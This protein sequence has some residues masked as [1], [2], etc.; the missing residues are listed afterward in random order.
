MPGSPWAAWRCP[1]REVLAPPPP[2]A[3]LRWDPHS[4]A[5]RKD[6]G[7]RGVVPARDPGMT[8]WYRGC[9]GNAAAICGVP[10]HCDRIRTHAAKSRIDNPLRAH[11]PSG[12]RVP[13]KAATETF[14]TLQSPLRRFWTP[15]N[16]LCAASASAPRWPARRIHRSAVFQTF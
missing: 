16:R 4:S 13:R 3:R 5:R 12:R 8:P 6:S 2:A 1:P 7:R 15:G 11:P 14:G 10:F 9:C